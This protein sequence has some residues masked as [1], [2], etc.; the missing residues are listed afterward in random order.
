[1]LAPDGRPLRDT[2]VTVQQCRHAFAFGNIAFDLVGLVGGPDP[3]GLDGVPSF[4]GGTRLGLDRFADRWL[5]LFN[6]ATLPFYWGRYEPRPGTADVGRLTDAARWLAAPGTRGSRWRPVCPRCPSAS[7]TETEP[8]GNR[9]GAASAAEQDSDFLR[10]VGG[11]LFGH[12]VS[13]VDHGVSQV[14]C[15][16]PPDRLRV[17]AERRAPVLLEHGHRH[18]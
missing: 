13:V 14:R 3:E 1:M 17:E 15:P 12:E 7:M 10:D 6:T 18:P 5:N 8:A 11:R 2:T 4:G 16:C 9:G